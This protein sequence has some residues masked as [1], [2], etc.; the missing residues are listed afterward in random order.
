M[1]VPRLS[2]G[3][4]VYNGQDFLRQALDSLVQ[5]DYADFEL[6][7]SDNASTDATEKMCRE[8]AAKD[9][10][11]RYYRNAANI[12][13]SGNYNRVF[14]LARGEFFKWAA[15]DDVHLPGCL[16][17]CMEVF[18]H[19]PANVALVAPA[20]EIIDEHGKA[21]A[22]PV[23]CLDTRQARPHERLGLIL[24]RV[25]WAPAQF[26]VYRSETLRKTRLIDSFFASDNVLLAEIAM[27]GEI[28]EIPEVLFQRRFHPGC[29]RR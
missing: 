24:E 23:E 27:L 5:Q 25:Y 1:P 14:E 3:V 19:A 17:R 12:G 21:T 29:P 9:D 13:A 28:R 8:Y 22:I 15:H 20:S 6:I 16:K 7:I 18:D 26:G 4:P 10:R 11:I 2:I